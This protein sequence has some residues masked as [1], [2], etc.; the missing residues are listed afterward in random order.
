MLSQASLSITSVAAGEHL[1]DAISVTLDLRDAPQSH[2]P[3]HHT[4]SMKHPTI[5][6][7]AFEYP[8]YIL[9]L[10]III[11]TARVFA[12]GSSSDPPWSTGS[13]LLAMTI[14][15]VGTIL[16]NKLGGCLNSKKS[17]FPLGMFAARVLKFC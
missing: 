16:L 5:I 7:K 10:A 6:E 4:L 3:N 8:S 12:F 17:G 11:A 1:P 9:W 14:A 13:L 2:L 15:P